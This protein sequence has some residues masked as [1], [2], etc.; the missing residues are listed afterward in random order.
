M[1]YLRKEK[2][3]D[4][5]DD[6]KF[7]L[8]HASEI[9][10]YFTYGDGKAEQFEKSRARSIWW[11]WNCYNLHFERKITIVM[12]TNYILKGKRQS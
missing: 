2:T 5:T 12:A 9:E 3:I 11:A 8:G 1:R 4:F 6:W 7:H 10:K